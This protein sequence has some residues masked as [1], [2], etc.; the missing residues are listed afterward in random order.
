MIL[1]MGQMLGEEVLHVGRASLERPVTDAP[2]S[3]AQKIVTC[4]GRKRLDQGRAGYAGTYE[5]ADP[6]PLRLSLLR[7]GDT[8]IGG[9]DGEVFTTIA[10]RFKRESP[11]K[12]TMMTTLTNGMAPSGYIPNDAAFGYNT[13]EVVSSRLKPGCAETAI[14][15]GLVDLIDTVDAK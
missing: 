15:E 3:G 11:F 8:V 9:V 5:D 1:S 13:F 7:I 6:I 4:P 12:H 10:Q 14:V 2:I